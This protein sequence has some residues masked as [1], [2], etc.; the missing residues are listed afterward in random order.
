MA[1]YEY[2]CNQ[3]GF[4]EMVH[5]MGTAPASVSCPVCGNTAA[6]VFSAPRLSLARHDLVKAIDDAAS[7]SERPQVVS[8]IP[9]AGARRRTPTAPPNP[10]LARLPRP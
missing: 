8:S 4:I 9:S 2:R 1:T 7:T 5:P 10:K 6:R 3:D